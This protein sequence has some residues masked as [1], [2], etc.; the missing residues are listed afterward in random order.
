MDWETIV[1][2]TC[3]NKKCLPDMANDQ[4]YTEEHAFIQF[5]EDFSKVQYGTDEQIRRQ[6]E[7]KARRGEHVVSEKDQAT[8]E[9]IQSAK[10]QEDEVARKKA[11]KNK[12]KKDKR[13]QKAMDA[14][15]Q[16]EQINNQ[17]QDELTDLMAN[18]SMA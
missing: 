4:F 1:I 15:K 5:S 3:G 6:Q 2:Y 12:R 7:E 10:N 18:F 11:E 16:S 9:E 8:Q 13:K 17:V 14:K